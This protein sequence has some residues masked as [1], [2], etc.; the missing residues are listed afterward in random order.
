[1][2][3][4]GNLLIPSLCYQDAPAAITWLEKAFGFNAHLVVPG[5]EGKIMHSQ[6]KSPD[7]QSMLM[8]FSVGDDE[9]TR[10][11]RPPQILGG[12]NQSLY[13]VVE[14]VDGHH[15]RAV[16]AGAEVIM[17]PSPQDYGGS[18]YTCRD[19]EGHVRS[20]GSYDPWNDQE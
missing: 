8:L 9:S 10:D 5:E 16:A 4:P 11:H 15:A 2:T 3:S 17:P 6:L 12:S 18:C 19:P 20:F 7:G 14:D 13:L 1:M